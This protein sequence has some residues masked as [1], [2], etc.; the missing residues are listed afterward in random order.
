M[1]ESIMDMKARNQ[2]LHALI[3][4]S[5][6]YHLAPRKEKSHIL[7]EYC[8][9]TGQNRKWVIHK[10]RTGVYVK[11]MRREK[12]EERRIRRSTY[13]GNVVAMLIRL[14][15]IFDHPCGQR[16]VSQI[17]SELF[18]L[19]G[20]GE[21]LCSREMVMK[22]QTISPAEIDRS[23]SAHKEKE[24]LSVKYK[25]KIHPLLYQKIPVKIS[26]EQ[27]RKTI[28][29]VQID[30]VEHCG[31]R[32]EGEYVYTLSTADLATNWWQGGAVLSKGMGGVVRML[33]V[34]RDRF[35]FSWKHFHSDNDSAFINGHL[36]RYSK[37]ERLEF[38]RSRPYEKND[39]FLA[40]QKNGRVVRRSVGYLRHDTP[41]EV[42]IL[43]E[44]YDLVGLYQNFFQPVMKLKSKERVGSKIKRSFEKPMTPYRQVLKSR[45]VDQEAK[46]NLAALYESLN[47]AELKRRID[48]KRDELYRAYKV[49]KH[50][51]LKVEFLKKR[52]PLSVRFLHD[53]TEAVSVR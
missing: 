38:T 31:Q 27:D 34:L 53:V 49:K 17:K 32:S 8:K 9:V 42:E 44:L 7:D 14:W 37:R 33:D 30:L 43:N 18:R 50:H 11:T 20:F 45:T 23:L 4:Q 13:D 2:Y 5:G 10:L 1:S 15:N 26:S 25:K 47:P 12:G 40:E 28:G 48:R 21:I 46:K 24:R 6:G 39:N 41:E 51:S 52:E 3:S 35:P 16:M 19:Q 22:L 36:Y 29:N